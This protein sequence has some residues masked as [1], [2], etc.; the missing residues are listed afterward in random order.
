MNGIIWNCRA[1]TC[2][3]LIGLSLRVCPERYVPSFVEMIMEAE[4][5]N[6]VSRTADTDGAPMECRQ[7]GVTS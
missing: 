2:E 4:R 6:T 1:W 5:R 7:R 3:I